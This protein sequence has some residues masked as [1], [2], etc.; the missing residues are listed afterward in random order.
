MRLAGRRLGDLN[1]NVA[2]TA[3]LLDRRV[4]IFERLAVPAVLVLDRLDALA[5]DRARH[6]HRRAACRLSRFLVGAIDLLDVVSVDLDRIPAEGPRALDIDAR[7]PADHGLPALAQPVHVDD[8]GQIVELVVRRMLV[9]L[10]HRSLRHLAVAAEHP[11]A[12]RKPVEVL[13]GEPH[14]DADRQ[15]LAQRASRNVHPR[16]QR[17]RVSLEHAAELAVREQLV[18]GD[19][20]DGSEDC[21]VER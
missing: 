7:V 4:W 11:D 2:E 15:A 10:P 21:V 8:G 12:R 6:D 19:R 5:L 17:S 13:G 18:V 1:V 16:D 9:R 20:P 14:P 3:E